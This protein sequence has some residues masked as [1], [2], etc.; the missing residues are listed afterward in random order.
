MTHVYLIEPPVAAAL[1]A[2]YTRLPPE[3]ATAVPSAD[4]ERTALRR[5]A[6]VLSARLLSATLTRDGRGVPHLSDGRAISLS[7]TDGVLALATGEGSVGV[8]I[9]RVTPHTARHRALDGRFLYALPTT[10]RPLSELQISRVV[11]ENAQIS[12]QNVPISPLNGQKQHSHPSLSGYHE[13]RELFY[14]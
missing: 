9:E 12:L 2:E 1:A 5:C 14:P 10:L 4:P 7:Y 3:R 13:R 11:L 8:D 6:C